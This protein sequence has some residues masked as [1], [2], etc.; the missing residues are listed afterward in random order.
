MVNCIQFLWDSVMYW[1][2]YSHQYTQ[3][4]QE[5]EKSDKKKMIY[6]NKPTLRLHHSDRDRITL[7][8]SIKYLA[9]VF[10]ST[11]PFHTSPCYKL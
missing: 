1:C 5:E 10:I 7:T 9:K 11:E 2:M 3:F 4:T 8:I 6:S